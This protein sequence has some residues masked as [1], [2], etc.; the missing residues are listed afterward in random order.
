MKN[1]RS[2]TSRLVQGGVL[3]GAVALALTAGPARALDIVPTFDTSITSSPNATQIEGSINS[4]ISAIDNLYSNAI[5]I[6][7]IFTNNSGAAGNL[8]STDQFYNTLP[9]SS[10]VADL[11]ADSTANPSN[12]T[13]S[14]AIAHLSKGNDANGAQN[15]ALSSALY[16]MLTG[17][18]APTTGSGNAPAININSNVTNWSYTQPTSSSDFDLTGG[19]EH[20][21]DEVLGAG[22][23]GSTLNSLGGSCIN[24]SNGFFCNKV[25]PLDLYRYSASN[26]PSFSATSENNPISYLSVDGGV[27]NI[28]Y[29]NQNQDGD[30]ADFAGNV[31]DGAAN[32]CGTML[33]GGLGG[34]LIQNAFNCTGRY[35]P[36]TADSPEVAMQ[37]SI[38]WD[39]TAVPEPASL[40]LLG[41]AAFGIAGLRRRGTR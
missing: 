10:Y 2:K 1:I 33:A 21:L 26:T 31:A 22:G 23:A 19:L 4:A 3:A 8:L 15:L 28:A 36:Y 39:A 18:S 13:L 32:Q 17:G 35:E 11:Q 12:T 20:E 41:M 38:G 34:E 29:F 9:Y 30:M 25:G 6:P 14:T 40:A 37:E 27:T 5:T 24:D 16:A 7:V